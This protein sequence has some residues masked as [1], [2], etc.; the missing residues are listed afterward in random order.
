MIF[1]MVVLGV[2]LRK[3]RRIVVY[4]LIVVGFYERVWM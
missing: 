2:F 1:I 3:R 4:I